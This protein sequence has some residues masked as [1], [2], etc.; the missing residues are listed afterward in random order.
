M[1]PVL[2]PFVTSV[3]ADNPGPMTLDGTRSY[4]LRGPGA[5]TCVV[6]DPGPD[7]AAHLAA[8]AGLGP[9]ALVLVTHRHAD[10]TAGVP[11]LRSLT[12]APVRAAHPAFCHGGEPLT[13]GETLDVAGL[14]V[15]VVAT[16]GHT[17]DS[18][19]FVVSAPGPA[20]SGGPVVLTGD[21]VLGRG[22]TMLSAGGPALR[23]YL[24]S[25][26]VLEGLAAPG[27]VGLPGHGEPV[28]DLAATVREYRAHRLARLDEVRA[29]LRGL[30]LPGDT[31]PHPDVVEQVRG[32]V[33]P[34]VD[35]RV[36]PA[37][38]QTVEAQLAYLSSADRRP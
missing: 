25:L 14:R 9:V 32:I 31:A 30:G 4:V 16:P 13:G 7:D 34:D 29:A 26:D 33:Y 17:D 21:T 3:R 24:A 28:A 12:G 2:P 35:P 37:A 20:G 36:L 19:C 38:R 1:G 10:H 11:G 27:V 15:G 6:V 5:E 23:N 18:V 22:T 8:L